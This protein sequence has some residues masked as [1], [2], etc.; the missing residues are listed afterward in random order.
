M[1]HV[2]SMGAGVQSTCMALMAMKKEIE[3][4]PE[5]GI[6]ADTQSEPASVMKQLDFLDEV[7]PFPIIRTTAGSLRDD[8]LQISYR[9]KDG[10]AYVK[11]LIPAF[12]EG[13]GLLGRKCTRD[14]KITPIRRIQK[15]LL[16]LTKHARFPKEL[17]MI[18]WLGISLDEMQRMKTS[19][20]PWMEFRHPLIE[21]KMSRRD[22]LEWMK[23]NGYPEPPRSACSFCPFHS[24]KEW[25]RLKN[26]EPEAFADAIKFEKELQSYAKQALDAGTLQGLP[27]LHARR[28][29]LDEVD[30]DKENGQLEIDFNMD[31]SGMCGV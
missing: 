30:F 16:G 29:P 5:A 20:E 10:K 31:C 15:E 27:F 2:V 19:T 3:P 13:A 25:T 6:F 26:E 14:Y 8:Q 11:T 18:Q 4:M 24:D 21:K 12:V 1:K 23:A 17:K 22:C 7:L 28:I 9:K